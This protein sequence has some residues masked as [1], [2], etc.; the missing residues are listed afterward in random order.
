LDQF[1]NLLEDFEVFFMDIVK[2]PLVH[3]SA[4][5]ETGI[6]KVNQVA[7]CFCL[8][9]I[10]NKFHVRNAQFFVEHQQMKDANARLFGKRF[11]NSQSI[12]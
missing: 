10:Q 8:R 1:E 4:A 2:H 9:K 3:P 12:V 7:A 6:L 11:K 5:K